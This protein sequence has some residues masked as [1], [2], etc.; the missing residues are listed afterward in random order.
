MVNDIQLQGV[1]YVRKAVFGM[2][3]NKHWDT[4]R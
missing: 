2:H 4:Q 3:K 1:G